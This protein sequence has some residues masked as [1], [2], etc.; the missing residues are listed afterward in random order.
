[1]IGRRALLG[2]AA[3]VV[4][5]AGLALT[6][7][8]RSTAEPVDEAA[9]DEAAIDDAAIDEAAID[10]AATRLDGS[11]VELRR[12]IHR[13]PETAGQEQRTAE[14][15][16]ERLRAAGLDV[17][18]GVGGYGVVG[19]L[20]GARPG[21]AVAYRA[22]MDAVPPDGQIV[23]GPAAAHVCGHDL[24]TT[25]GV[26]IA[27]VLASLR[28]RL[29]GTVVFVFQPGEEALTGAAAMLDDGVLA[30]TRPAEIHALHCG[31]FPVGRFATAPGYGLPG[32]DRGTVTLTGPDAA[33]QARRL[34]AEIGGL[35]TVS[36]P[37]S[38]ADLERLVADIQTP[39]GPLATFVFM[40][41]AVSEAANE[42]AVSYRCW[43]EERHVEVRESIRRLARPYDGA[44][45]DFPG[46]PFPAM[47]CPERQGQDLTEYLRGTLGADRVVTLHA[48]I[49]F[50][51]EDFALFL[52][53]LPGT[54][55]FLGVRAP[56]SALESSYPH[57][58]VFEP[59]ER[60]I[61]YGVR[62]MAGWL[63]RR[64]RTE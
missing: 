56:G 12:D 42:V 38:S 34:A 17:T 23:G 20:E 37:G 5:G 25:I 14:L 21:R 9:I 52:D 29:G 61:G 58:G 41:A 59:D 51:G 46:G 31:P 35:G 26:G 24:H 4:A 57:Y 64:A 16:A 18:T 44:S 10:D 63:A 22:D 13:H 32:Q 47:V 39:D 19:V 36:P 43:P 45:V 49:P 50:S 54:F 2:G 40:R 30:G 60:A 15:V 3:A 33:E 11:L 1:M 28:D 27:E 53:R 6:P 62:A 8:W 55:T 7:V 48:A